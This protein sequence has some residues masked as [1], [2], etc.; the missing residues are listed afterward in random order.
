MHT[1]TWISGSTTSLNIYALTWQ[2]D[3][4]SMTY[5]KSLADHTIIFV[6]WNGSSW[7]FT[8]PLPISPHSCKMKSTILWDITPRSPLKVHKRF[9]GTYGLHFQGRR[10]SRARNQVE[11]K[12]CFQRYTLFSIH[13]SS[14]QCTWFYYDTKGQV[15]LAGSY[16]HLPCLSIFPHLPLHAHS[17]GSTRDYVML[18]D[19]VQCQLVLIVISLLMVLRTGLR[20]QTCANHNFLLTFFTDRGLSPLSPNALTERSDIPAIYRN[21]WK[22]YPPFPYD[23]YKKVSAL[24]AQS[25]R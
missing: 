3:S 6:K 19:Q 13:H 25:V 20:S 11:W 23:C 22:L 18:S 17:T 21:L 16:L 10:I 12:S 5:G 1:F 24:V 4:S 2:E 15:N 7:F 9:G 14:L 8:I